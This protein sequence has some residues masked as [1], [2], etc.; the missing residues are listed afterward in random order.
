M[1]KL[2]MVGRFFDATKQICTET[3]ENVIMSERV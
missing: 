1:M 2:A 3:K